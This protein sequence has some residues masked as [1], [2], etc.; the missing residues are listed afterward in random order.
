MFCE[1]E[2]KE[3]LTLPIVFWLSHYIWSKIVVFGM[4]FDQD[5]LTT[6]NG[7]N[8]FVDK[9]DFLLDNLRTEI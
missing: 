4:Q 3:L 6:M 7:D 9:A 5:T 2:V 8:N 1:A